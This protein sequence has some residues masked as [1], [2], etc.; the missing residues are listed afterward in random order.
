M[1]IKK[2]LL[3]VAFLVMATAIYAQENV[4]T[5]DA[6]LRTRG[7]HNHG[8]ITPIDDN[9]QSANFINERARLSLGWKRQNIEVKA[10]VQHTGVWGQDDIKQPN[11]RATMNE[12]WAKI[13]TDNGLFAKIGRQQLAYDDE[14]ILGGL[15]WNVNGN[16]HDALKLGYDSPQNKLHLIMA[17]NQTEENNRGDYYG[18]PMP[19]KGMITAW[20]HYQ[21]DI[22]PLGIS[23]MAMNLGL[24]VGVEGHGRTNHMQTMGTDISFKPADWNIHGAFYYQRGSDLYSRKINAW[25]AS[26]KVEYAIDPCLKVNVG[27]DHLSGGTN[28][29]SENRA[30]N[31]LYGTHHK[32]YGAMD[33]FPGSLSYGLH[34]LQAGVSCQPLQ[35]LS[36]KLDYHYFATVE[37]AGA[38]DN[39]LGHELDLQLT[40]N[41]MKDVT[42]T[43][44]FSTMLGTET[45]TAI[46]GGNHEKFQDWIWLQLN[47]NPRVLIAKW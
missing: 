2:Q 37:K 41:A 36:A 1:T 8:A 38:H 33:Y 3:T 4:F 46:K 5:V 9:E 35:W 23:L 24:E 21:S 43:A 28:S 19:Y 39:P 22:M 13:S 26:A 25:M 20:Y 10:S 14:R 7:E 30:F 34:D 18:G 16:W 27:Y 15:D 31:A 6:Q 29:M 11:G 42:L 47:I 40:A 17:I 44:G 12:A 45:F 32:F